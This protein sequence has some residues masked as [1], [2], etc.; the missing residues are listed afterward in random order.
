MSFGGQ[1]LLLALGVLSPFPLTPLRHFVGE[2]FWLLG[3]TWTSVGGR[4]GSIDAAWHVLFCLLRSC[5]ECVGSAFPVCNPV[6]LPE[7][8]RAL[9]DIVP[10]HGSVI[11]YVEL[12]TGAAAGRAGRRLCRNLRSLKNLLLLYCYAATMLKLC[13]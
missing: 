2:S 4:C 12:Q 1:F 10:N 9:G 6:H 5:L 11:V 3:L 7:I 13:C 8:R